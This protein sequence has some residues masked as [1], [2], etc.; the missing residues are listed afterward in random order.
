TVSFPDVAVRGVHPDL[1]PRLRILKVY[2]P[3][4]RQ[5]ALPR[6]FDPH[7]DGVM[8]P[9]QLGEPRLPAAGRAKVG[10]QKDER[11]P[12]QTPLQGLRGRGRGRWSSPPAGSVRPPPFAGGSAA[13]ACTIRR[14]CTR[15]A[16]GGIY[17]SP[18]RPGNPIAPTL[19]PCRVMM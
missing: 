6:V 2:T 15:P 13:S 8:A 12:A 14:A 17:T 18:A 1:L 9:A 3:D 5:L 10:D 4:V 7:G 16:R 19:S 11:A